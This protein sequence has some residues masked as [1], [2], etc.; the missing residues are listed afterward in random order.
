MTHSERREYLIS[1]LLAEQPQYSEIA[2]PADEREQ[3]LL[4]RALFNVRMP[5]PVSAEFLAVQDAY[6][7]EETRRKGITRL[8]ELESV[9]KG[10]YLRRGDITT[11]ECDAIVNAANSGM[12]G[13]FCPNHGCIDNAIHTYAGV[14]LRLKCAG[15]MAR[16]GHEEETGRAKITPAYNLPCRY[17]LHTVGPIV[18]ERVTRRDR[19][20]LSACYRAC[21]ELA[22]E[23]GVKSIAFCCIST[24]EFHFPNDEAAEIALDTGRQY[25]EQTHSEIE[26]IFNVFKECDEAIYRRL[27]RAD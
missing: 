19:E 25:K 10:I 20:E 1:A 26:V 3:K 18:G 6:L 4:L 13:C 22:D 2:V 23:N 11:L 24:G 15:L 12:L 5:E 7:Q 21:L 17:I 16:Q 8:S 27:L 14:Q 9:Q